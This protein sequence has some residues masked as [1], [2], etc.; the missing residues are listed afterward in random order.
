MVGVMCRHAS[1][2]ILY[3]TKCWFVVFLNDLPYF[4]HKAPYEQ[5]KGAWEGLAP[6]ITKPS[7]CSLLHWL[8]MIGKCGWVAV[9][10][11]KCLM[12]AFLYL[13]LCRYHGWIWAQNWSAFPHICSGCQG[14]HCQAGVLCS[15]EVSKQG[16]T[17]AI[18][19]VCYSS[20]IFI[21]GSA[22]LQPLC[23]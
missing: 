8:K 19:Q 14:S 2:I 11:S 16:H 22:K 1:L 21:K 7:P 4:L 10:T 9:S 12:F 15:G 13:K 3:I 17:A 18:K 5:R 23:S 20:I 6:I